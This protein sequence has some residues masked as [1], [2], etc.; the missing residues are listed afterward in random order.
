MHSIRMHTDHLLTVCLLE[1]GASMLQQGEG[2]H[3]EVCIQG[4]CIGGLVCIQGG[5]GLAAR[6]RGLA[7]GGELVAGRRGWG[8]QPGG[9]CI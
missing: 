3:P 6:G 5:G 1:G 7:A 4:G 9:W 8:L 2:V